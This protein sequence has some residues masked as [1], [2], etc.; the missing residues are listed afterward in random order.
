MKLRGRKKD[1]SVKVEPNKNKLIMSLLEKNKNE[2]K[3]E[4]YIRRIYK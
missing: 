4:L 1:L 2:I 3:G